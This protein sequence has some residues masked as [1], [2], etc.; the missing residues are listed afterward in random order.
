MRRGP[1]QEGTACDRV[2]LQGAGVLPRDA[3]AEAQGPTPSRTPW[4][5]SITNGS[6]KTRLQPPIDPEEYKGLI[7][8]GHYDD[9]LYKPS[10]PL[11][12]DK[13]IKGDMAL[14]S[15]RKARTGN[16]WDDINI[17]KKLCA[18]PALPRLLAQ[19]RFC[20]VALF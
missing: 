9:Y 7:V 14:R 20:F 11:L 19:D 12:F 10:S 3:A 4:A 13:T 15:V 17:P 8:W 2:F 6:V 5:V 18:P 1:E 16:A